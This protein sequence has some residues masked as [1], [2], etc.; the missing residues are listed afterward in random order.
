VSDPRYPAIPE[1][2]EEVAQLRASIAALKEAV[3]MLT[4]QRGSSDAAAVTIASLGGLGVE[5]LADQFATINDSLA[6]TVD[7]A[8]VTFT[9]AGSIAATNVQAA[10]VEVDTDTDADF[11]LDRA[12]L[13]ALEG[14]S[15]APTS[16]DYLVKTS[17]ALLSAERVV[18]D[19]ASIVVD[20]ST[21]GQ[22]KFGVATS[23]TA[24]AG[25]TGGGSLAATVTVDVGAG[26]GISVNANDV[27]LDT[28]NTRNVDH[29]AVSVIAGAG[30]TGG[31]TIAASRTFAVGAG[32]GISVAADSVA[33]DYTV[34]A[35]AS[36]SVITNAALPTRLRETLSIGSVSYDTLTP[37]GWYAQ[38]PG[39][40]NAPE[41]SAYYV[42]ATVYCQGNFAHQ[43]FRK[44]NTWDLYIRYL[45]DSSWSTWKQFAY[46]QTITAGAG[47]TGGGSSSGDVTLN[48]IA[49]AN[50]GVTV[51]ADNIY[52]DAFNLSSASL[53][54][55]EE[56]YVVI[57]DTGASATKNILA[58]NAFV[59][60]SELLPAGFLSEMRVL[61]RSFAALKMQLVETNVLQAHT[62][63][64]FVDGFET[65]TYI[66]D[67]ASA[68]STSV[69]STNTQEVLRLQSDADLDG[70]V[71]WYLQPGGTIFPEIASISSYAD[72]GNMT[73]GGGL[74]VLDDGVT[75]DAGDTLKQAIRTQAQKLNA[76]S[77][78]YAGKNFTSGTPKIVS[79]VVV[80]PP[81]NGFINIGG[82]D[83]LT[84]NVYGKNGTAPVSGTDPGATLLGT[85][86]RFT[87][88]NPIARTI[89][90]GEEHF[91]SSWQYVWVTMSLSLSVSG[92]TSTTARMTEVKYFEL[93]TAPADMVL[94]SRYVA[95]GG[96]TSGAG[97][98]ITL[99]GPVSSVRMVLELENPDNA[100]IPGTDFRCY[101]SADATTISTANWT[102]F[103]K[104]DETTSPSTGLADL[105]G[106]GPIRM[107]R[108]RWQAPGTAGNK[109]RYKITT[110]NDK[111][112]R[113]RRVM[114]EWLYDDFTYN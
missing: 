28:T 87:G 72:I 45:G 101:F 40:T 53:I 60:A 88:N 95:P 20:W 89:N 25:L 102:E 15:P 10:I 71:D 64:G 97:N 23:V 84:I 55:M 86:G 75:A 76:S 57:Y 22:A 92:S 41:A 83:T 56:D 105:M 42:G 49:G 50:T 2:T 62:G 33:V 9:P 69:N 51:A 63:N 30:L 4:G 106:V 27:A 77:K 32:T 80:Y 96:S 44:H 94:V 99:P 5:N 111:V 65:S 114:L 48:V 108:S 17:E 100:V 18:T 38:T 61:Q 93:G 66:A 8:D 29:T 34:V 11:V 104:D 37:N 70:N 103:V 39:Q 78:A 35:Q 112:I 82:A 3:E 59:N 79:K 46:V 43:I 91:Q 14:V 68:S 81:A 31:G 58:A 36:G 90:C 110:H 85:T 67:A 21:A 7:A 73:T 19:T 109:I 13:T 16:A 47:M 26:T 52:L 54:N 6:E 113:I 107:Y 74:T 24:G 98:P 1:P 12:R